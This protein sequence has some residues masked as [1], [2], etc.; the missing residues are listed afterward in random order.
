MPA[1]PALNLNNLPTARL[2]RENQFKRFRIRC[3][4]FVIIEP[5]ELAHDRRRRPL[6][7]AHPRVILNQPEAESRGLPDEIC[8]FI[9]SGVL[10]AR[11]RGFNQSAIFY[12]EMG[13]AE[14][15]HNDDLD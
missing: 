11:E 15:A 9:S 13:L 1:Q 7:A 14:V 3:G 5:Q 10:R 12:A 2:D 8:I 4:E 6:I